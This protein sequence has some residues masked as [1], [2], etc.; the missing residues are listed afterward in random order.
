MPL[1][2]GGPK[3][4]IDSKSAGFI[5]ICISSL[6]FTL[7]YTLSEQLDAGHMEVFG[8]VLPALENFLVLLGTV[9]IMTGSYQ[10]VRPSNKTCPE[11]KTK[12]KE[13][14]A[15]VRID[16]PGFSE[17]MLVRYAKDDHL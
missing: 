2:K 5:M 4:R 10:A 3:N 6:L 16:T 8:G 12:P 14:C 9:I 13:P 1:R 11:C 15:S 7:A 17:N